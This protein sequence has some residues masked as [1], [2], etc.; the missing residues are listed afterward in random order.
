MICLN[1]FLTGIPKRKRGCKQQNIYLFFRRDLP[2]SILRFILENAQQEAFFIEKTPFLLNKSQFF[3][4]YNP[5]ERSKM[6]S[7]FDSSSRISTSGKVLSGETAAASH[8]LPGRQPVLTSPAQG[9]DKVTFKIEQA[10]RQP[11]LIS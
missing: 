3:P 9:C 10:E 5:K 1:K 7:H 2:E 11:E 6:N 4:S 8:Y